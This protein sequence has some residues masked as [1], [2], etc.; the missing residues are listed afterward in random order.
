VKLI[1]YI[2]YNYITEDASTVY[3]DQLKMK[4]INTKKTVTKPITPLSRCL[5]SGSR[6]TMETAMHTCQ[7]LCV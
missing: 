3:R 2:K 5:L 4:L 1:T 7:A 6:N